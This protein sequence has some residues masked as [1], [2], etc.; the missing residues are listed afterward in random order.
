[1]ASLVTQAPPVY[2]YA[3]DS[4]SFYTY[5]FTTVGAAN[6]LSGWAWLCQWRA[7]PQANASIAL[8]VDSSKA[9]TG[10]ISISASPAAT[11]A[12]GQAGVWDLQGTLGGVVK[13]W[14]VGVTTYTN[15]VTHA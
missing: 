6:D 8:D 9:S 3:G 13:T 1:M 7:N 12:M 4:T 11:T 14:L 10:I 2:V 5:T 15:D